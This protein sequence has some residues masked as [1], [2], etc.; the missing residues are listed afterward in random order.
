MSKINLLDI[1]GEL[2]NFDTYEEKMEFMLFAAFHQQD[3]DLSSANGSIEHTLIS[4][5]YLLRMPE[6]LEK[7]SLEDPLRL[8]LYNFRTKEVFDKLVE[9]F[10]TF[11]ENFAD[12]MKQ[13][14]QGKYIQIFINRFQDESFRNSIF[15]KDFIQTHKEKI[16]IKVCKAMAINEK[17]TFLSR[18]FIFNKAFREGV[19]GQSTYKANLSF[20]DLARA[21]ELR[22]EFDEVWNNDKY[23]QLIQI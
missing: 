20:N 11:M 7:D 16:E 23:S 6:F 8:S 3:L 5:H 15:F 13:G 2:V 12:K 9:N 10:H 19:F 14:Y 1:E 22:E 18:M 21:N 4:T 17:V